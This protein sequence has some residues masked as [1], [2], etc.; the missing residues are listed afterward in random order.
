[1]I[2][3][4]FAMQVAHANPKT[5]VAV[6]EKLSAHKDFNWQNPNRFRALFGALMM[7]PRG[8]STP[9]PARD[10]GCLPTG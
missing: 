9:C 1:M 3:K 4:W 10:T 8:G 2:D 5:A 7:N 6:A